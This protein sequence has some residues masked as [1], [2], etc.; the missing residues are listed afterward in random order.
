[1]YIPFIL[2]LNGIFFKKFIYLFICLSWVFVAA[3]RLS[4][5]MES[6][7]YSPIAVCGLFIAVASLAVE[8]GL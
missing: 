6:K 2:F 7:D 4:L 8:H 3:C 1:M 5:V